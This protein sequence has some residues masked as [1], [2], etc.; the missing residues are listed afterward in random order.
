MAKLDV[1]RMSDATKVKQ[2]DNQHAALELA[3]EDIFG[4]PDGT[5]IKPSIFG[6][7]NS[8][9][10]IGGSPRLTSNGQQSDVDAAVGFEFNDGEKRKKI[11][12]INSV[13]T[14]QEYVD[15][16]WTQ[17]ASLE[18]PGTGTLQACTDVEIPT[19]EA[20]KLLQVNGDGDKFELVDPASVD[21]ISSIT[22][23]Y[24]WEPY[25]GQEYS[26]VPYKSFN[27]TP[28]TGDIGKLLAITGASGIGLVAAPSGVGDPYVIVVA[29]NKSD[30]STDSVSSTSTWKS[31]AQG[32]Y[33][34][35]YGWADVITGGIPNLVSTADLSAG[36]DPAKGSY[37]ISLDK[38]VYNVQFQYYRAGG[39]EY[40]VR[41]WRIGSSGTVYGPATQGIVRQ[42]LIRLTPAADAF[43]AP[44]TSIRDLGS[45]LLF[46]PA[47]AT[48]IFLEVQQDSN[49]D[50][51][52]GTFKDV[53]FTLTIYKVK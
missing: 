23:L 34:Q 50:S 13:L 48:K 25:G 16:A 38:G 51:P 39:S 14:I 15:G 21:G 2:V 18:Q 33:L 28:A 12:Y 46:V 20:N 24:E 43:S 3:L 47:D 7:V 8:D 31:T 17:I 1:G 37:Y 4:I 19:M 49:V 27:D 35:C 11:A 6:S 36:P 32:T 45:E 30:A 40:G 26:T 41:S 10:S 9:G 44:V 29:S 5:E 42:A 22:E 53:I 52:D